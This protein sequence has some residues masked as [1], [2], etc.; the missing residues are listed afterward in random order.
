MNIWGPFDLLKMCSKLKYGEKSPGFKG[1]QWKPTKAGARQ[2]VRPTALVGQSVEHRAGVLLGKRGE[3]RWCGG[4]RTGWGNLWGKGPSQLRGAGTVETEWPNS[5]PFTV[6]LFGLHWN[7]SGWPLWDSFFIQYLLEGVSLSTWNFYKGRGHQHS[8]MWRGRRL[9]LFSQHKQ[10]L[11]FNL[12]WHMVLV[13]I[14]PRG[15]WEG[16]SL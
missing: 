5:L 11:S 6:Y 7:R 4:K 8:H 14:C 1:L 9:V 13:D 15:K 3:K 10:N 16:F 12:I 2:H